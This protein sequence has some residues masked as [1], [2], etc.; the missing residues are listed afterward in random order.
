[1]KSIGAIVI[2]MMV[3][4][5]VQGSSYAAASLTPAKL[6]GVWMSSTY[7]RTL[8]STKS[9]CTAIQTAREQIS[10]FWIAKEEQGYVRTLTSGMH[11][12]ANEHIQSLEETDNKNT[13]RMKM[14][15][16][17][18]LVDMI[19]VLSSDTIQWEYGERGKTVKGIFVRISQE[20]DGQEKAIGRYVNNRVL[21]GKYR[22]TKGQLFSFGDDSRALWVDTSFEYHIGLDYTFS[23]LD[24]FRVKENK[25]RYQYYCF[26]WENNLLKVFRARIEED[27]LVKEEKPLYILT[28]YLE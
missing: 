20:Q 19:T 6:A 27:E 25:R 12:S 4:S 11:D 1:M 15:G 2:L 22:D 13:Y 5:C 9:P 24:Y 8:D 10:V 17:G 23:N 18:N 14:A 28:P 3:Y 16:G 26:R 7:L 21:A